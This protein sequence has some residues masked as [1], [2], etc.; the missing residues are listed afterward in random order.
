MN[1]DWTLLYEDES[2]IRDY[3]TLMK[4]WFSKGKQRLIPTYGKHYS[5]KL[6]GVL[7][8][9]TGHVLIQECETATASDF[10]NFLKQILDVYPS[11]RVVLVLDNARIHHAKLLIPFLEK[12]SRL[13]LKF[14]PPYSP[15]LNRIEGLWR[16]L[17][18]TSINN[19][20]FDK[21][22]KIRISVRNFVDWVN[23]QSQV[24]IDR[25]CI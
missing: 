22:Y 13:Y 8:Y 18:D 12:H 15:N 16:W 14:L 10:K 3:Q 23:T 6:F 5:V 17:K 1:E 7:D 9:E 19:V 25:L 20:F 21:F 4:S 24:V 2:I 11:G